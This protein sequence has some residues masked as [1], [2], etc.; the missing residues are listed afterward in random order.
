MN[1]SQQ[2]TACSV[3]MCNPSKVHQKL[4][5]SK[6]RGQNLPRLLQRWNSGPG[7]FPFDL[8]GYALTVRLVYRH[9]HWFS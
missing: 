8:H 2:I 3:D 1:V 5:F 9:S 7:D 4:S 6:G